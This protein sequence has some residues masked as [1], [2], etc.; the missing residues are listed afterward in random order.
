MM[1]LTVGHNVAYVAAAIIKPTTVN[2]KK[3]RLIL[4]Q[5][6]QIKLQPKIKRRKRKLAKM[7]LS[8]LAEIP[9]E[10]AKINRTRKHQRMTLQRNK[11]L[12][13]MF[14]AQQDQPESAT[15]HLATEI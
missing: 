13:R 1:R 11:I 8:T 3:I 6:G 12:K 14:N 10:K 15:P 2:L 9:K 4:R 5:K 7:L